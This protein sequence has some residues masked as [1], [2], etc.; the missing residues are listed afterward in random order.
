[1][2]GDGK[3]VA[4]I[5]IGMV[6]G[7]PQQEALDSLQSE[8]DDA[9]SHEA[10][11]TAA[12]ARRDQLLEQ[13]RVQ[14]MRGLPTA[15]DRRTLQSLRNLLA[16]G[17]IQVKVFTRRPVHGKTYVFHRQDLNTPIIGFVG[18]SNL[19]APGLTSNLELNVDVVDSAAAADLAQWFEDRWNDR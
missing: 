12:R 3:P 15:T 2:P 8:V 13:L 6:T 14:L 16:E 10:D 11:N 9:P 17:K 1:D 5:L 19:T 7:G 4:R 18:S